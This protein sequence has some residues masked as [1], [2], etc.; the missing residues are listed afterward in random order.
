MRRIESE[1]AIF[2]EHEGII[3]G[4][5]KPNVNLDLAI[6]MV[7]KENYLEFIN[8]KNALLISDGRNLKGISKE[9]RDFFGG[10][11]GIKGV[12]ACALISE[13]FVSKMII[14]LFLSVS[15]PKVPT[16]MFN[17]IEEAKKWILKHK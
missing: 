15:K 7:E 6:A 9:A 8:G 4:T 14:N 13:S 16:K 1:Y 2:E 17:S 10:E 5:Y 11:M 3:I 12:K